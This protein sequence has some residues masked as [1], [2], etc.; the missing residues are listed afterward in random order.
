MR[1]ALRLVG[2][3]EKRFSRYSLP[4]LRAIRSTVMLT[5]NGDRSLTAIVVSCSVRRETAHDAYREALKTIMARVFLPEI[6]I[7]IA[8]SS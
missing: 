4:A 3:S 2:E 7:W 6:E 5:Y 8:A 1:E